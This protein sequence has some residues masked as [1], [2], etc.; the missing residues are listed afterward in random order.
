VC[1]IKILI[2][3]FSLAPLLLANTVA[4]GPL[5]G[6]SCTA[7]CGVK[8]TMCAAGGGAA[9]AVTFGGLGPHALI[10]CGMLY[11]G[12]MKVCGVIVALPTV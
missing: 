7:V 1:Q 10:G 4:A 5:F 9:T 3:K 11:V 12:C 8:A 6:M 2:M